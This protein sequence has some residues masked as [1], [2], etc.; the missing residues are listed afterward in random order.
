MYIQIRLI[1]AQ[2]PCIDSRG[3]FASSDVACICNGLAQTI[4]DV[5][6]ELRVINVP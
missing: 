5:Q 3:R 1:C 2:E 4:S 6:E